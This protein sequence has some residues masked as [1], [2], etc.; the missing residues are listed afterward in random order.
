METVIKYNFINYKVYTILVVLILFTSFNKIYGQNGNIIINNSTTSNTK[1]AWTTNGTIK[2]FNP[3]ANGANV[4]VADIQTYLASGDVIISTSCVSCSESGTITLNNQIVFSGNDSR[5]LSINANSDININN[6]IDLSS[7]VVT[8]TGTGIKTTSINITSENGS[9]K[10]SYFGSI[11]TKRNENQDNL[12]SGYVNLT[13]N[14]GSIKI[15]AEINTSAPSSKKLNVGGNVQ[16]YGKSGITINAN[17]ITTSNTSGT[18]L[19]KVDNSNL[20]SD[21]TNLGQVGGAF[22]VASFEKSGSGIFKLSNNNGNVNV[23]T[24]NTTLTNGIL[25]LGAN[26][27]IPTSSSIIFNGGDYRP[28]GFNSSVSSI[29]ITANST[30]TFDPNLINT[31]TIT[32]ID[33]TG[34]NINTYLIIN[35]WQGFSQSTA[36]T[37]YGSLDSRSNDFVTT[38]GKLQ[39]VTNPGGLNQFGQIL[40]SMVLGGS[41]GSKGKFFGTTNSLSDNYLRK[42]RFYNS[43][44]LSYYSSTQISSKEVVPNAVIP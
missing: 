5:T 2:T 19:I 6:P 18:L 32:S 3:T 22:N 25:I 10:T 38:N 31:F 26:N 23:W 24:G 27:S 34:S 29:K 43:A 13:A 37:K 14:N 1:G 35:G 8:G 28:N 42:I 15:N 21:S 36:L 9:I 17:I 44:N 7:S 12:T 16:I 4:N 20:S 41:G 40:T 30:L 39:S 11:K 33:T